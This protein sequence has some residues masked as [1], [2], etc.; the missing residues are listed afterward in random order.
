MSLPV[1]VPDLLSNAKLAR[2]HAHAKRDLMRAQTE[3]ATGEFQNRF[4]GTGGDPTRL[5]ALDR[6]LSRIEARTPNI[7]MAR[8]RA[9]ATQGAL[10][11]MATAAGDLGARLLAGNRDGMIQGVKIVG[12]EAEHALGQVIRALN[13]SVGGRSLFAGAAAERPAILTDASA[14]VQV[15]KTALNHYAD[16][17]NPP[18]D[19]MTPVQAALA[20]LDAY[21][22]PIP[23]EAVAP[24]TEIGG[25]PADPNQK[26][27]FARDAYGGAETD[28]PPVELGD[29]DRLAYA[30]RADDAA[31]KSLVKNLALAAAVAK[32]DFAGNPQQMTALYDVAG[33]RLIADN[34]ELTILRAGVGLS[35][36]RI[37]RAQTRAAG[38]RTALSMARADMV[39]RDPYDAAT[40]L[41]QIETQL[42]MIYSITARAAN[43]SLLS[44]LR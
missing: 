35:E 38:E 19:G 9:A 15:A 3:V 13:T 20:A 12:A 23:G 17:A 26:E 2:A 10:G 29:D 42:Q 34:D 30:V 31:L 4:A 5:L 27:T 24:W 33:K 8:T 39:N 11:E 40:E 18:P 41:T 22:S 7:A 28:A 44:F 16:G 21:F 37:D 32:S 25:D 1:G 14:L 43:L 6:A 36:Q